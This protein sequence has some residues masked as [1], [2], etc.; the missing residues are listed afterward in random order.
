MP[1]SITEPGGIYLHIPFCVRKCAYCDFYS[2]TELD[3]IPD[4]V[5]A[6]IR[7]MDLTADRFNSAVDTVYFGGGTPSLLG[8]NRIEAILDG[9]RHRHYLQPDTEITLEANPGAIT[10]EDLGAYRRMGVN[11]LQIGAQSFQDETL[12]FLGRIHCAADAAA[13]VEGARRAGFENIGLDLIYGLP[14]QSPEAWRCD[15]ESAMAM[16]P[17][18]LSCYMLSYEP[19]TALDHLRRKGRIRPL[20][21]RNVGELFLMTID[22]LGAGGYA[23]Y[24]ISNFARSRE[25]ESRHNRKYW[26]FAPYL[27][28]GPSAHSFLPPK[29]C[30]N[31]RD[32]E[33]YIRTLRQGGSPIEEEERLDREQRMM[34]AFYLGLRQTRGISIA[35]FEDRFGIDFRTRFGGLLSE[36]SENG[37]RQEDATRCALTPKGMLLLDAIVSRF[38]QEW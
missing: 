9:V 30:W 24:E 35:E 5:D 2:R 32:T 8:P 16:A 33:T 22:V 37:W 36:L 38:I 26:N 23:Q 15:L 20:P 18:H 34:E 6:M 31:G 27:G 10:A 29:R 28:L 17:E 1:N 13:A 11:R 4:F 3:L 12:R 25:F 19:G 14:G 21:D 7:E